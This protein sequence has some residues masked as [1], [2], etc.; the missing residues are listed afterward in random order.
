MK[1]IYSLAIALC[2]GAMAFAQSYSDDFESYTVGDMIANSSTNWDT[3]NG[4]AGQDVPVVDDQASSGDKAI[5]FEASSAAGGPDDVILPFGAQYTT[6]DFDFSMM[7]YVPSGS[8]AYFN[9]QAQ[10]TVGQEWALECTM[11]QDGDIDI[12]N[13]GGPLLTASFTTGQWIEVGFEIDLNQNVWEFFIDGVSQGSFSNNINTIAALNVYAYNNTNGGNGSA[14]FWIDDVSYE[15]TAAT[16]PNDN[17]AATGI[18][19]IS[20][21]VGQVKMPVVTLRNLGVSNITAFD[22][23]MVYNGMTQTEQVTGVNLASYDEYE[24]TFATG[25]SLIDGANDIVATL[26][27]VNGNATDDDALDDEV[28]LTIDPTTPGLNKMVVVEEA[29]GTWCGWCPRGAVWMENLQDAYPENFIGLAVHNGD[30]MVYEDYDVGIG[31]LISG[32]PSA[33]VDRGSDI[34]PSAMETDFLQR[35]VLNA[36]AAI[37]ISAKMDMEEMEMTVTMT[38]D[39]TTEIDNEWKVA[40]ALSEND[41]TGTSSDYAQANYYS[42]GG[43]GELS[44][45]GHDWHT[46][47]NPVPA[48]AMEYDHVAR[49]IAPS[50]EGMD[51][52]FPDGGEVGESY[53][54]E[55]I[56]DIDEDWDLDKIHIIGMLVDPNGEID[57]GYQVYYSDAM[58]VVCGQAPTGVA[59]VYNQD[60]LTVY[61]NPAGSSINIKAD[62]TANANNELRV[63]DVMG[64]VIYS[65]VIADQAGLFQLNLDLSKVNP[66]VYMVELRDG[67]T[68]QT[69]K[70]IKH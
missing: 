42:G 30:P 58:S 56:L 69:A 15:H 38:V 66:G 21:L 41:V 12:S 36:A 19:P 61:P 65:N 2:L 11:N 5:Y 46:A 31:G 20:G 14:I 48:S 28:I 16:L 29:T 53:E 70:F 34:D 40:V 50:F 43:S 23:D 25:I 35:V 55:F 68:V 1:K 57:N 10:T 37:C 18:A 51:D 8:G 39:P 52:A 45:A 64:R 44:G 9:F 22:V 4:G 60:R 49:V 7:M 6:G 13:T 17:G 33:V 32:Y 59:T 67:A 26:K 47:A 63:Y 24:V 27:N 3:W 62:M 54:F